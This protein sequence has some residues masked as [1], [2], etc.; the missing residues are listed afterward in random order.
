GER[1]TSFLKETSLKSSSAQGIIFPET[2]AVLVTGGTRGLGLLCARHLVT[3]YGVK[4]LVLTGRECV[5]PP[6]E[7]TNREAF[8]SSIQEKIRSIE[9]LESLGAKLQVRT[10]PLDDPEEMKAQYEDIK[11]S[12]GPVTGIIHA[13]G[14]SD[15]DNPAF[16]RKTPESVSRILSPKVEGLN[17]LMQM[18][19]PRE[20]KFVL[21]FSSVSS[22]IPVLG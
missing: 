1:Y 16:I 6:E 18:V 10:F 17:H 8:S 5:P 3:R 13:A 7:W 4:R 9:E 11:A 22:I 20:L 2:H 15:I 12:M 14:S 19:D 21:L